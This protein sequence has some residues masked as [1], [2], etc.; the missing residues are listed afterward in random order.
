M[1]LKNSGFLFSIVFLV[2]NLISVESS[3]SQIILNQIVNK[4]SSFNETSAFDSLKLSQESESQF[5]GTQFGKGIL[6]AYKIDEALPD[7]VSIHELYVPFYG[8]RTDEIG[9]LYPARVRAMFWNN[10]TDSSEIKP[11]TILRSSAF[12]DL[13][14]SAEQISWVRFAFTDT[15]IIPLNNAYIGL[16]YENSIDTAFAI[17]PI[18]N[19]SPVQFKPVYYRDFRGDTLLPSDT[20]RYAHQTFWQ[21][22][23]KIGGMHAFALIKNKKVA[24]VATSIEPLFV[25]KSIQIKAF[26]N[27]FNP[28][29]TISIQGLRTGAVTIEIVNS[30]GQ[31]VHT[32]HDVVQSTSNYN[33]RWNAQEMASGI[34]FIN[35]IQNNSISGFTVTLLK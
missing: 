14:V 31:K 30:L 35:V 15:S 8:G 32:V 22:P 13:V 25:P 5:F 26:P 4:S 18:F 2:V 3:F 1:N 24:Q 9:E 16:Y 12:I 6:I 7:T 20:I 29:T 27:P 10:K 28:S 19:E 17:S 33:Y 23:E 21:E 11:Q 34:Y